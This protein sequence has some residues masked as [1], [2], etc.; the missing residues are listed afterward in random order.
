MSD[1]SALKSGSG[2]SDPAPGARGTRPLFRPV[3][4]EVNP[5]RVELHT[6][7]PH[8]PWVVWSAQNLPQ[9][10]YRHGVLRLKYLLGRRGVYRGTWD[11]RARPFEQR[12][13][14]RLVA[15][16]YQSLPEYRRSRWYQQGLEVIGAGGV[17]THKT[18]AARDVAELDAL[19]EGYLVDLLETMA[20]EGYRQRP[21]ADL[22]EAMIGRDGTLIK[23]AHGTHRLASAKAAGASGL[24]P[25]RVIGVHR[26]WLAALPD[27]G[28]EAAI[29]AAL[30]EIEARYREE[31]QPV[32]P[33]RINSAIPS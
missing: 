30:S 20:R 18:E 22:P 19:F 8:L 14:Y 17:F 23:T 21:G 5:H 28:S 11:L 10:V 27:G 1:R 7:E 4:L 26:R 25:L 12:E 29:A 24:F 15:D 9:P 33:R 2:L 3:V 16:L 32:A 13:E 31:A 6:L